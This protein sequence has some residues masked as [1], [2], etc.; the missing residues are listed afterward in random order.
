MPIKESGGLR[1]GPP[2]VLLERDNPS[3]HNERLPLSSIGVSKSSGSLPGFP[4]V[5]KDIMI[6]PSLPGAV[7]KPVPETDIPNGS[8]S[9]GAAVRGSKAPGA[10]TGKKSS[11]DRVLEKLTP[12]YPNYSR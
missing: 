1:E 10:K 4:A 12:M 11:F 5:D 6:K 2:G 8:A 3:T 9:P 7:S